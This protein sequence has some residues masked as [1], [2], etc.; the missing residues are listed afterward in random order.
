MKSVTK[1][2]ACGV[3]LLFSSC[4]EIDCEANKKY[5]STIE[6]LQIVERRPSSSAYNLKS[7]GVHLLTKKPCTCVD[8]TRWLGCYSELLEKGDTIIKRKGELR[9]SLHKKDTII[10][11][12][13]R[14]EEL[15]VSEVKIKGEVV[16]GLTVQQLRD[17]KYK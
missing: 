13:W 15:D 1:I 16:S 10:T 4:F 12:D 17:L 5:V 8:E 7:K 14:C 2:S 3:L 9:F 11:V 6:C